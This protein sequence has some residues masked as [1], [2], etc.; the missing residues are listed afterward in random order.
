MILYLFSLVCSY[1]F[2]QFI[3][4]GREPSRHSFL[5]GQ[6]MCNVSRSCVSQQLHAH[7]SQRKFYTSPPY[8][9]LSAWTWMNLWSCYEPLVCPPSATSHF[10]PVW[11][12]LTFAYTMSKQLAEFQ[13]SHIHLR[14]SDLEGV[15]IPAYSTTKGK[16]LTSRRVD[17]M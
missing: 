4:N 10:L 13:T 6:G 15:C 9:F 7:T 8:Y 16:L 17:H 5:S 2:V 14:Y 12:V 1:S 3:W 11:S